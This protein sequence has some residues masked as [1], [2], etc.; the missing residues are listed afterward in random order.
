MDKKFKNIKL[1][2]IAAQYDRLLDAARQVR[3]LSIRQEAGEKVTDS[4]K[5]V[6]MSVL[7]NIINK[8]DNNDQDIETPARGG[9]VV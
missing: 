2:D 7:S 1:I 4:E 6:R 3:D 8:I 5:T 9:C